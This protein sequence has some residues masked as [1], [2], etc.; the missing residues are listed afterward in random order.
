[1][2][3]E[4]QDT[5]KVINVHETYCFLNIHMRIMVVKSWKLLKNAILFWLNEL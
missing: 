2:E 4:F 1:M 5:M 3:I